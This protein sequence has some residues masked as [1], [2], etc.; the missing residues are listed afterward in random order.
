[1]IPNPSAATSA[2]C[3]VPTL[4]RAAVLIGML[5]VHA[6]AAAGF[7][8]TVT[9]DLGRSVTFDASPERIVSLAPNHSE[10]VCA[11]GACERL[12]GVDRHSDYPARL[13]GVRSL[14]DAFAPDIEGIVALQPDLVLVDEYSSVHLALEPLGIA[15]YAGT[16]QTYDE[17][18]AYLTLLGSILGADDMAAD[19]VA[20]IEATVASV[21][22]RLE[23][24]ER[25]TVFFEL[26]PTPYSAGPGSFIGVILATA[27]GE[28]VVTAAMGD[29]PQVDPEFVV[30]ADPDVIVLSDAPFGE[31]AATVAAR[32][33]WGNLTAVR[34]DRV[35]ELSV[36][37][38]NLVS[39]A[40]PRIAQAVELLARLLHPDLF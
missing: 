29:F 21:V 2:A 18:L 7:P 14:G 34:D 11:L 39:R 12:V 20:D 19:V 17:T 3:T 27:G 16:P 22:E 10:S 9:D 26:D 4:R 13:A 36:D 23:G 33:G 35:I 28:N 6:A 8:L 31:S 24:A 37:E 25:P 38:V 30:L 40:G 5:L 32:P 15:V 1:M